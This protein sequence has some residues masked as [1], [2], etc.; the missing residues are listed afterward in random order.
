MSHGKL[1]GMGKLLRCEACGSHVLTR[2]EACPFCE[3]GQQGPPQR[4]AMQLD[5][6]VRWGGRGGFLAASL[7]GMTALTGCPEDMTEE[8]P[9]ADMADPD[10]PLAQPVY[11]VPADF[12]T[13]PG[14][15]M[16][17][18]MGGDIDGGKASDAGPGDMS[19]GDMSTGDMGGASD[20]GS[21]MS[22]MPVPLYGVTPVDAGM[23][24][25]KE[26]MDAATPERDSG[27]L[28]VPLYGVIPAPDAGE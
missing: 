9:R 21:D 5:R 22:I 19:V 16:G 12:G 3:E 26:S 23:E 1:E 14:P 20:A 28:P 6:A 8:D 4:R 10:M 2:E 7:M 18:D 15:D 17:L 13:P 27:I 24:D 25:M 11:G